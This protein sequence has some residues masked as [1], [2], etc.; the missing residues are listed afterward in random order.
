MKRDVCYYFPVELQKVY[1]GLLTA[2]KNPPFERTCSEDPYKSFQFGLSYSFKYNFN[3]G[4][5]TVWF[6]PYQQGTAVNMRFSVA[7]L[8][9]AR[10][11]KYASDLL[12]RAV[13]MIGSQ[14]YPCNVSVEEFMNQ[15]VQAAPA[16]SLPQTPAP[17][18]MQEAAPAVRICSTCGQDIPR[19]ARFCPRCGTAQQ[20]EQ[21]E[22]FCSQ[23]GTKQAA[24]A[25]FCHNCGHRL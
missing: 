7:Q 2:A 3:G 21:K 18:Q 4:S 15:D 23:C 5:V 24:G 14:A 22:R 20:E 16:P 19:E 11:E 6:M 12:A 25:A 13:P 8:A 17:S 1:N 10:Y 9:G